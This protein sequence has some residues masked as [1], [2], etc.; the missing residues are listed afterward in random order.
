MEI[1]SLTP[2]ERRVWDAFPHGAPVDFRT[3]SAQEDDPETGAGWGAGRTVRA[4]VLRALLLGGRRDDGEIP[5]LRV[6]GAR[7]TGTLHLRYA[8]AECAV[9]LAG[10]H[11]DEAPN[12]YGT[13]L[14]QLNLSNSVL[15][16]LQA[17]TLRV[18]GVLRLTD[19]RIPGPVHLGGSRIAQALFF[20]RT[21]IGVNA[22]GSTATNATGSPVLQLNQ[23]SAGDDLWWP[24]LVVHGEVRINDATVA[25]KIMLDDAVLI[26]P[27]ATALDGENLTVGSD[28]HGMRLRVGGRV[29]LRG[30]RIPGQLNLAYAA[31]SNPGGVAVRASSCTVGELWL[32]AAAPI[33]GTVNLR[34]SQFDLVHADPSVWP[35]RVRTD[36]MTYTSLLPHL[37]APR[38]LPLLERDEEGY[39]PF[40]YEQL[41]AAYRRI[42]DDAAARTVQLAKLRRR[43]GTLSGYARAWGYLQ[44]AT[45]GY[46]FR[47]V[48]AAAW[49][50]SLLLA[51]SVS[52]AAH[53]P[54]PL[55]ADEAPPFSPLVYTLDLLLPIVDFGQEK[56]YNPQG[57]Y[58][59]LSYLLIVTGWLLA[60]TIAAGVTRSVS[61]Q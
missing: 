29:N 41:T 28:L 6:Q 27:G 60:T 22:D 24:G 4:E 25:G 2:A 13:Q 23:V 15:P 55:K 31:L 49:L 17:A 12:L 44:D 51:G 9:L 20:D 50:L 32:R 52:Y 39:M 1:T 8:V 5:A 53:H 33:E 26:N 48:R 46:G 54:R 10:C 56:A 7:I 47:P 43:R 16:G 3:G 37:P 61:R 19:C 45:V 30:A 11:F 36:Q 35:A 18:D 38:R 21:R 40:A 34:R 14:R 42:G 58:Q 57:W 59:W